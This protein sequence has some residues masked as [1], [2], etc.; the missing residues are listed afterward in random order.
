MTQVE[1]AFHRRAGLAEHAVILVPIYARLAVEEFDVAVNA[2]PA[3]VNEPAP[4]VLHPVFDRVIHVAGPVLG[5][6]ADDEDFVLRQIELSEMQVRLGVVVVAEAFPLHP[7][8]QPPLRRREVAACSTHDRI[9]DLSVFRDRVN[10]LGPIERQRRVV[11]RVVVVV[12][13]IGVAFQLEPR[14]NCRRRW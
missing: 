1:A 12:I 10:R 2:V 14:V 8:Q 9:V 7:P 5:V 11:L 6:S 3:Q 4:L 13:R